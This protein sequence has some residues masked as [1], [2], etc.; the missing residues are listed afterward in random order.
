MNRT[1][2][3][4]MGLW[5][6]ASPAYACETSPG[7]DGTYWRYRVIGGQHCWYSGGGAPHARHHHR[8]VERDA[9]RPDAAPK[10]SKPRIPDPLEPVPFPPPDSRFGV[11]PDPPDS[12][13]SRW[14][15]II[16]KTR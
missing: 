16:D 8:E 9:D 5:L 14:S 7:H 10:P 12:F 2:T 15:A 11:W 13:E 6:I 4:T 3:A 1:I